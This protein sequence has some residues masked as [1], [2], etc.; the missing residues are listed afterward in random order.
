MVRTTPKKE[1][2][3]TKERT[4]M[5][6]LAGI[7]KTVKLEDER[8]FFTL[9]V[10]LKQWVPCS[11]YKNDEVLQKIRGLAD[12]DFIQLKAFIKPWSQ[13]APDG[14][15][16]NRGINIEITE[17]KKIVKGSGNGSSRSK[18]TDDDIPF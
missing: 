15:S 18:A 11:T 10:G 8:A 2:E 12:G 16:W 17:V 9:D 7:V 14:E 13:K 6:F 4:N 3:A 5:A 1:D